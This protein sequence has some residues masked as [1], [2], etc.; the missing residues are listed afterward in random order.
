MTTIS[1]SPAQ[2]MLLQRKIHVAPDAYAASPGPV[3]M[4]FASGWSG[5]IEAARLLAGL[6]E[7][8]LIW[9]A[10]Q[11]NGHLLLTGE[12]WGYADSAVVEG[13]TVEGVALLPLEWLTGDVRV[14]LAGLVRPLDHLL[15]CGGM[16]DGVWL[17]Q[18]GGISPRWQRIGQQIARLFPLG[19]GG[20]AASRQDSRAYLAEGL[21]L[22]LTDRHRLNREDP[23]L[24]RLLVGSLLSPGFWRNFRA[25]SETGY[26]EK[27]ERG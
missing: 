3:Q 14:A 12:E 13:E 10:E 19:Y 5:A 27:I 24:E 17:S 22:A 9:W 16:A 21:A 20:T 23:K 11:P 26:P 8:G 6:P 18:G 4:H 15:G 1:L 2:R 25:E 7:D